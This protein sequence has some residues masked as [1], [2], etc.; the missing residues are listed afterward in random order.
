MV[1]L[2]LSSC[3]KDNDDVPELSDTNKSVSNPTVTQK[4][5]LLFHLHYYVGENEVFNY[6]SVNSTEN[7]MEISLD[8][9]QLYIS[10]IQLEKLD[11][12]FYTV[13]G[14][15]LLKDQENSTYEVG[16]VPA[17]NYKGI[18]FNVGLDPETNKINPEADD[19]VLNKKEMWFNST[20][21][22]GGYIFMNIKGKVDTTKTLSGDETTLA[23]FEYR[24]GEN[25]LSQ[26]IMPAYNYTILP[27]KA[28][29]LHFKIDVSSLFNG[30]DLTKP[31]NLRLISE[32]DNE[33]DLAGKLKR[34]IPLMFRYEL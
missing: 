33:S 32:Q 19:L 27:Q 26:V 12:T 15:I 18:R 25:N 31:E 16:E 30:I 20:A 28:D 4:G 10:N 5:K 34:N 13:S 7:G 8:L 9:A 1:L 14:K 23:P 11:G 2:Q 29:F 17:G 24:L 22:P 21:Q 6:G 3:K